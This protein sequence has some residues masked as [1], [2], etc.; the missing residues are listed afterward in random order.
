MACPLINLFFSKKRHVFTGYFTSQAK[1]RRDEI[2]RLLLVE[3][4]MRGVAAIVPIGKAAVVMLK[5][6]HERQ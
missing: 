4:D 1:L 6:C 2:K 5:A 3:S